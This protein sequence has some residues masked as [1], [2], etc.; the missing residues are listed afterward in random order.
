LSLV[1]AFAFLAATG[2]GD[3]KKPNE[4]DPPP[5]PEP[6]FSLLDVNTSSARHDDL[7]S[8]RDYMGKVSAY[9]FGH[10]T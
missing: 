7:V 6:D 3:D 8:P 10:A 2:C 9:Y 5:S 1:F 4:P